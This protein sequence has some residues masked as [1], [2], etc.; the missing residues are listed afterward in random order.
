MKNMK[1]VKNEVSKT[2]KNEYSSN[3]ITP[4]FPHQSILG[5]EGLGEEWNFKQVLDLLRRRSLVILGVSTTVMVGVVIQLTSNPKPPQY[6]SSFQMLIEPVSHSNQVIDL[7]QEINPSFQ[8]SSLDYESQI[9]VLKSPELINKSINKLQPTYPN[10]NYQY[11]M[12]RFKI[13]RLGTT[14]IL[15]IRYRSQ[16]PLESKAVLQQIAKDY[17]EYSKE[18][19]QTNLGQGLQYINREIPSLQNRVDQIQKELQI[20]QQR[21]N[22]ISPE[23]LAGQLN[24]QTANLIQ[25]QQELELK[26]AQARE[27]FAF[28]QSEPGTKAVLDSYPVYQ[29]LNT[30]LRQ[31]NMEIA[32]TSAVFQEENPR[33]IT[34]K[35]KRDSLIPI[36]KEES[37]RYI[38]TK[39]A[40]AAS[41][42]RTLEI[43]KQELQKNQ[44]IVEQQYQQLPNL[45]RQYTEIQSRLEIA[46]ESLSRFLS[47]RENLQI[48]NSQTQI[49]W[50]LIQAPNEPT[51]PVVS[52]SIIRE[53]ILGLTASILLSIGAALLM[54]KLDYTYHNALSLKERVK[55]PLLGNIPLKK[56]ISRQLNQ[57]IAGGNTEEKSGYYNYS[58]NFIEA[59]RVL[60][61]NIQLLNSDAEIE[62]ITVTS[63]MQG[64]GK[65]TVAFHLA[66]IAAAMGKQV[67]LV[68][69]DMRR[70]SI[71]SLS[72]LDNKFGLS[73]LITSNLPVE[74]VVKQ[75]PSIHGLSIIPSGPVPPDC[76][77]LLSSEK[78]KRLMR[79]F[80]QT[81][82]LVIYDV[83]PVVGL[84]DASLIGSETDGV[85]M[86]ARIDKT[87]RSV[88]EGALADLR[89]SPMNILGVVANG[90][91]R[92]ANNYY[93]YYQSAY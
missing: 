37:E 70:P 81:F 82:D 44:Q 53:M 66:Q 45:I 40:E 80:H 17:L 72:N 93:N 9:L 60:Y 12:Q 20:F 56:E 29:E 24:T 89:L 67:L 55:V 90:E 46:A 50:Q 92:S 1:S 7:V 87:D 8:K 13:D 65:S 27:D 49:G 21:Y 38:Q 15:E 41:A 48:Q 76:A 2:S 77:K 32:T 71:H 34:L 25:Q 63:A 30:E 11:L 5:N 33:L 75:L 36:I 28:L 52:S 91:K 88:L 6:E 59:V 31:L 3:S 84:A 10:I 64:D 74:Q 62:S 68:D 43:N 22:F 86:I 19:R 85:L 58:T 42:L 51:V 57:T 35:E 14:K 4:F 79:D 61:T 23:S 26:L 69:A 18:K 78:M 73:S 83:P 47:N 54:E 39:R 16:D